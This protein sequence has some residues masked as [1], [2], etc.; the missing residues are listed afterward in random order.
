MSIFDKSPIF[1][2]CEDPIGVN[3]AEKDSEEAWESNERGESVQ[4]RVCSLHR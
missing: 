3:S 1:C 4:F 2:K